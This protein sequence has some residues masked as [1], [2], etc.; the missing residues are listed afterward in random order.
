MCTSP[1]VINERHLGIRLREEIYIDYGKEGI[2]DCPQ[3]DSMKSHH[4]AFKAFDKYRILVKK[5]LHSY[6]NGG[7]AYKIDFRLLNMPMNSHQQGKTSF[8]TNDQKKPKQNQV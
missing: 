1:I 3:N 7:K 6:L 5:V 4:C 8:I 2:I